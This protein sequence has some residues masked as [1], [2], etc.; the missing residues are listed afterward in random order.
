MTKDRN[1]DIVTRGQLLSVPLFPFKKY[2]VR[3]FRMMAWLRGWTVFSFQVELLSC[4]GPMAKF[5]S[6][7][8]TLCTQLFL[9]HPYSYTV[10]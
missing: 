2:I 9:S 4:G 6:L 5:D 10:T 1:F 3:L 8:V 7:V